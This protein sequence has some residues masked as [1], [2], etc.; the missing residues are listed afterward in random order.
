MFVFYFVPYNS[1]LLHGSVNMN[2]PNA[3]NKHCFQH[4]ELN[5]EL[6]GKLKAVWRVV[7][8]QQ[9]CPLLFLPE[10]SGW[11]LSAGSCRIV[12]V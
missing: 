4:P 12:I 2:R 9:D 7:Q 1:G 5:G 11:L 8:P 3:C 10:G 6:G